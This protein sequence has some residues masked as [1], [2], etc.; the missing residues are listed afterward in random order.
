MYLRDGYKSW[1]YMCNTIEEAKIFSHIFS[2]ESVQKTGIWSNE[3]NEI[4]QIADEL[5][6][7][8][9]VARNRLMALVNNGLLLRES[10]KKEYRI[11]PDYITFVP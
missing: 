4:N 7:K 3:D 11:N 6:I 5:R 9:E 8:K 2:D 1:A 10:D